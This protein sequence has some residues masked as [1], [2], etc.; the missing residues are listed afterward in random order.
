M[1]PDEKDAHAAAYDA[2]LSLRRAKDET[3]RIYVAA[4]AGMPGAESQNIYEV[5]YKTEF[6]KGIV[7]TRYIPPTGKTTDAFEARMQSLT[8]LYDHYVKTC[9]AYNKAFDDAFALA[10][11]PLEKQHDA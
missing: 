7:A 1:T 10:Y 5:L 9:S 3:Q 6:N 2:T 11:A 8:K 4:K